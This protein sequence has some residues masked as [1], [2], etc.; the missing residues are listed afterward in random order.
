MSWYPKMSVRKLML[1]VVLCTPI[2]LMG[3]GIRDAREAA[4]QSQCAAACSQLLL[5]LHNYHS[6][7]NA[8][9]PAYIADSSG[10]PMHSWRVLLLPFVGVADGHYRWLRNS[11]TQA[12]LR[13]LLTAAGG[14]GSVW[15]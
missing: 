6:E 3:R 7:Y 5:A 15:P 10:K 4:R 14:E 13:A 11:V 9:P 12:N 8:L 2:A 1:L